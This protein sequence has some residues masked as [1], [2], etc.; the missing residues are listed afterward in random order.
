MTVS[1]TATYWFMKR[2]PQATTKITGMTKM[3]R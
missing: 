1:P 2:S 3:L